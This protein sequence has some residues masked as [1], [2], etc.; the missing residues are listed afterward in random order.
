MLTHKQVK[1]LLYH[2]KIWDALFHQSEDRK[3]YI[4]ANLNTRWLEIPLR[5][6]Y[7]LKIEKGRWKWALRN[8]LCLSESSDI[9]R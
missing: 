6:C 1:K 5:R 8:K 4:T 9:K 2:F 7:W 3:V